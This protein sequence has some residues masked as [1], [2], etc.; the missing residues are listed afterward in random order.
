VDS[1]SQS[2]TNGDPSIAPTSVSGNVN[3][4]LLPPFGPSPHLIL[5]TS[6]IREQRLRKK[7][8]RLITQRDHWKSEYEK[9]SY[10]LRMFPYSYAEERYS[11]SKIRS[12]KLKRLS[13]YDAMVPALVNENERLKAEIEKLKTPVA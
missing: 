4:S 12:E 5:K 11:E 6:E 7:I 2:P 3:S 1:N 8:R 10:I 13:D 9:L